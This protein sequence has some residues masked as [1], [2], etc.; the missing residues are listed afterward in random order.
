MWCARTVQTQNMKTGHSIYL[1]RG[2]VDADVGLYP[3]SC[4]KQHTPQMW[5]E[6][7]KTKTKNLSYFSQ[8]FCKRQ[9][10][11]KIMELYLAGLHASWYHTSLLLT[12]ACNFKEIYAFQD[13]LEI[14][15]WYRISSLEVV[16]K[17]IPAK[18]LLG[19][20]CPWHFSTCVTL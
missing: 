9:M 10:K 11:Q 19:L 1:R 14:N 12:I 6:K 3:V 20:Q 15:L 7:K 13:S 2:M 8:I 5:R 17:V 18:P 16:W 4:L